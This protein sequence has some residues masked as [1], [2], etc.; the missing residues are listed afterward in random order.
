MASVGTN[1]VPALA[2]AKTK[3]KDGTSYSVL[4]K[5]EQPS[6]VDL[7]ERMLELLADLPP[8]PVIAAPAH[9]IKDWLGLH[10]IADTHMGATI[11]AEEAGLEY[12]REIAKDR[13]KT[14]FAQSNAAMPACEVVVILYNGDTTH[15]N[16]DKHRT[17]KSGHPLRVEGSHQS[18]IFAIEEILAW[19]ID[20]SLAKHERVIVAIKPGNHDP[21]TPCALILG[22]RARYRE[23]P[24]VTV[25]EDEN[26]YFVFRMNRVFL[27]S[28]HGDGASPAKRALG[29]PHKFRQEWGQADFH[30]FY[31]GD[32]HHAKA[33]TFGGLHWRQVPAIISLEQH[34]QA[35]GYADT[36]GMY[37]AWF[38]TQTGRVS[39]TEIRF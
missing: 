16:D 32:K 1:L 20:V 2:W 24:R 11:T 25:I 3:S 38:D 13:L 29:I 30:W 17:P 39:E 10:V 5:P 35:E 18:N 12:N 21:N 33:D 31:T 7:L 6:P 4:L 34:S 9:V 22:M 23:N 15:S 19:Q 28:H 14:G 37:S 26:P 8:A 36:S 27:V